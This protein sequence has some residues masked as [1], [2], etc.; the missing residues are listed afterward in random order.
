MCGNSNARSRANSRATTENAFVRR[1]AGSRGAYLHPSC[2]SWSSQVYHPTSGPHPCLNTHLLLP[3]LSQPLRGGL[4]RLVN[5]RSAQFVRVHVQDRARQLFNLLAGHLVFERLRRLV[6]DTAGPK[7]VPQAEF[8]L[9]HWGWRDDSITGTTPQ[10]CRERA[11][12]V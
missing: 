1:A 9:I 7:G 12:G 2:L 8:G 4:K 10:G 6:L 11:E 3:F 5:L